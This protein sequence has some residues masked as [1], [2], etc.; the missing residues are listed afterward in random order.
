MFK[1]HPVAVRKKFYERIYL[2]LQNPHH[3]LLNNHALGGEWA[4]HR[5]INITGDVRVVYREV[6][7]SHIELVAI[8]SHSELY[9]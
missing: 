8:G 1:K 5:S 3:P 9:S 6:T 7:Q 2:F 4:R